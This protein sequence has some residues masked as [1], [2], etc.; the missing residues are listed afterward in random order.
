MNKMKI[1]K[2]HRIIAV[3]LAILLGT[4]AGIAFS[5]SAFAVPHSIHRFNQ[6]G[7]T[8]GTMKNVQAEEDIPNLIAATGVDGVSGYIRASDMFANEAKSPEEAVELM[9]SKEYL[10]GREI[11]L[12]DKDGKT[13]IGIFKISPIIGNTYD[14]GD[15]IVEYKDDYKVITSK[16]D[17]SQIITYYK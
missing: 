16:V 1:N 3:S 7:E 13:V 4:L 2:K 17:G 8:Y 15:Y 5:S 9:E 11:P 12:Y 14:E 10:Q 6:Q